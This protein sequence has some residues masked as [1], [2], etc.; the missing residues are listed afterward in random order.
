MLLVTTVATISRRRR[1]RITALAVLL[2][3]RRREIAQEIVDQRRIVGQVAG[4][5]LVVERQLRVGEQHGKLGPRQALA[6]R[7]A[8][9]DLLVVGQELDGAVE[10]ARLLERCGSAGLRVE[11]AVRPRASATEMAWVCR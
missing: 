7:R 3:D 2:A 8:A 11:A 4:Q 5:E 9:L 10:P 1:W 6:G